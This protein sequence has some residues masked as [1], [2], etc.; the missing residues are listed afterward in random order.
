VYHVKNIRELGVFGSW[1]SRPHHTH[2]CNT[3]FFSINLRLYIYIYIGW[4]RT[5]DNEVK[6]NRNKKGW[7]SVA[8][9]VKQWSMLKRWGKK[10]KVKLY[11]TMFF[12]TFFFLYIYTAGARTE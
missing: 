11:G 12:S 6:T 4:Q 3:C 7:L 1:E 5:Y 2:L 8:T 9:E 10:N